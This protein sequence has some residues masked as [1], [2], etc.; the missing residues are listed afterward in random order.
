MV[1]LNPPVEGTV[2]G[3]E[4]NTFVKLIQ[5]MSKNSIF[6]SDLI[7]SLMHWRGE[8]DHDAVTSRLLFTDRKRSSPL[9]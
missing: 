7:P 2:N 8:R 5:L 9:N 1:F 3:T 6:A 4:Q